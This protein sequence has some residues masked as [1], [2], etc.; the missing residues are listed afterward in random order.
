M[1]GVTQLTQGNVIGSANGVEQKIEVM[2]TPT[3]GVHTYKVQM[4]RTGTGSAT[5]QAAATFPAWIMVEDI[6]V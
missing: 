3:A 4:S 1:E 6:G 5:M 2:L